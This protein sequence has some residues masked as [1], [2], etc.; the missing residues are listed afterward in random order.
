MSKKEETVNL[1]TTDCSL[2][3]IEALPEEDKKA[4]RRDGY[5]LYQQLKLTLKKPEYYFAKNKEEFKKH[6]QK[7]KNS[8][9]RF[10]HISCHGSE[11]GRVFQVGCDKVNSSEL[12]TWFKDT[13]YNKRITFS[14]CYAGKDCLFQEIVKQCGTSVHSILGFTTK[15]DF[16]LASAFW[17]SYYTVVTRLT[18]YR[19]GK[20][21]DHIQ[22]RG[23]AKIIENVGVL[24]GLNLRFC[25]PYL[26]R[27]TWYCCYEKFSPVATHWRDH[28][29]MKI[30]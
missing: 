8:E 27:N 29:E 28:Q 2:F 24:Y 16:D 13:V 25:Y 30:S 7:F 26:S 6:L 3:I 4:E 1:P 11:T 14:A 15:V 20:N 5:V 19:K 10:L 21:C 22:S 9:C 12:A 17:I 23:L 18:N